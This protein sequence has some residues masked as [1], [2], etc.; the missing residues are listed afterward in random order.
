MLYYN[1]HYKLNFKLVI[2]PVVVQVDDS[3]P[4]VQVGLG[5]GGG[6]GSGGGSSSSGNGGGTDNSGPAGSDESDYVSFNIYFNNMQ[7]IDQN[8]SILHV[9]I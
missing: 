8:G 2:V 1:P 5:R 3:A 6:G 7:E 4:T 9:S